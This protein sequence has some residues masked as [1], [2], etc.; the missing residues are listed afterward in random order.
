M[1]KYINWLIIGV[2]ALIII[3]ISVVFLAWKSA[4]PSYTGTLELCELQDSVEVFT[5]DYGIPHISAKNR[6]D[7]YYTLGFLSAQ[8][9]MLQIE[10]M[11]R[12][13]KGQ[14]SEAFGE[15][16]LPIDKLFLTLGTDELAKRNT[17][18][19]LKRNPEGLEEIDAFVAGVNEVIFKQT[20]PFELKLAGLQ[21]D[22][23]RVED[24]FAIAAYMAYGFALAPKTDPLATQ[25]ANAMGEKW[26]NNL[27]LNADS[28]DYLSPIQTTPTTDTTYT[29][30]LD[31]LP[32]PI[33]HGSNSWA[34]NS[35]RTSSGKA[36][37][38]NDTHI[39]YRIP[40]VWYEAHLYCPGFEFYGNFLPGIPYALVGHNRAMGWGLTMFENDD[41]DFY[42][43]TYTPDSLGFMFENETYS[44]HLTTKSIEVKN[45]P[46][47]LLD[48]VSSKHGPIVN[49]VMSEVATE[50]PVSIRWDYAYGE[51]RLLEAFRQMNNA[52]NIDQFEQALPSIH[53]P[54]L[55]VIY[56][57]TANHIAWWACA[58]MLKWN[59]HV[60][61]KLMLRGDRAEDEPLGSQGFELNPYLKDP[62]NGIIA[63]ANEPHSS[64]SNKV[65]PGYYVPPSRA[66]RIHKLLAQHTDWNTEG[67]KSLLMD[68][69]CEEDSQN[70]QLLLDLIQK[71]VSELREIDRKVLPFLN[72]NGSYGVDS[73]GA[74]LFQR[75]NYNL[76][77]YAFADEMTP[78]Q[79]E[80]FMHLHWMKRSAQKLLAS[81][82]HPVWD[83]ILTVEK[84]QRSTWLLKAFQATVDDLQSIYGP[85][86]NKWT[87]GSAHQL[88]IKH[89]L[90]RNFFT[91]SLF[92]LGPL[93]A[94]GG[95]ETI[96]QS[97]FVPGQY[98]SFPPY[99]G[100]QMRII[101]DFD[102]VELSQSITPCGQS[103]HRWSP[104]YKDQFEAYVA[105]NFRGQLMNWKSISTTQKR[106]LVPL[107]D[108]N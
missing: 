2:L 68:D 29:D 59:D 5:D 53:G 91:A 28:L 55:N 9:R 6:K 58:R 72:W 34:L 79:F 18:E 94:P 90:A 63:S 106:N 64:F 23:F 49:E 85:K 46:T 27:W 8:E 42:V 20:L 82:D 30:V 86:P 98:A 10:L 73:R 93:E 50:A 56:A 31:L 100:P 84:E 47:V 11:R 107:E 54:G 61:T 77:K 4:S 1:K 48:V 88:T 69:I 3:G 78:A 39:G 13:S 67:M 96:N 12:V 16:T 26:V 108:P 44:S 40:Q 19:F 89:P 74:L 22:T 21:P 17:A 71:S 35:S 32:V 14:L 83:N 105:G 75:L 15:Q 97:G 43:E 37:L 62:E 57:D 7:L 24:I 76:L 52:S 95:N 45:H 25:L 80:Q 51:N 102:N 38:C 41:L 92:N 81:E 87:W 36:I 104:Y 33:F 101:I 103:G 65:Y 66:K 70:A 99:F 60:N